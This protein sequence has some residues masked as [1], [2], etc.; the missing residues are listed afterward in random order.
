MKNTRVKSRE[1]LITDKDMQ[2]IADAYADYQASKEVK[3]VE[4]WQR[5]DK[6]IEDDQWPGAKPKDEW[7]PKPQINICWKTLQSIH[8]NITQGRTSIQVTS[9][10]P[11]YDDVSQDVAD[12]IEYYWDTLDMDR[13]LSELEWIRPKL[14]A[15][16]LKP[17]W[18]P[19]KANPFGYT[20]DLETSVVHPANCFPDPNITNPWEI[21]QADFID[22]VAPTTVKYIL[23]HFSRET[24]PLCN[25][26]REELQ[27]ILIP[28]TAFDDTEIYGDEFAISGKTPI[29]KD[30]IDRTVRTLNHRDRL[31]LHEYWYRDDEGKLQ[32]AW[33]AGWV[34]LKNTG[35][36]K[37]FTDGFYRHG[38]YP[39][40]I[41]P[42]I[43][44]D[45]R[46]WGRS[47]MQA[48]VARND[49]RDGLQDI[50]NK[51][52]QDYLIAFKAQGQPKLAYQ[53]GA[54]KNPEKITGDTDQVI[55]TRGIPSQVLYR[56]EGKLPPEAIPA[57]NAFM[58]FVDG[59]TNLWDVTQGRSTPYTQT[60]GGTMALLEQA[61]R[62][63][64]DRYSTLNDGLRE[65]A[66]IWL[67]HLAE[68][69]TVPREFTRERNG[70]PEVFEF[71]PSIILNAPARMLS[72]DGKVVDDPD[73][74]SRR[75]YFKI[76]I[77]VGATMAITRSYLTDLG[78]MLY[79]RKAIDL[80]GLYK[81]LPEF[82]GKQDAL[83]RMMQMMQ[84][85]QGGQAPQ[86]Q[87]AP[88]VTAEFIESLPP[89]LL[90][91]MKQ[92]LADEEIMQ[93]LQQM[94]QLPPE[95][96]D[97]Y[98]DQMVGGVATVGSPEAG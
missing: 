54:V 5:Y 15:A 22:Y 42:Y 65:M 57:V 37:M 12:V 44:R 90:M 78:M 93:H 1:K 85:Q 4:Q 11:L 33:L 53:H 71:N 74:E 79:E 38:R 70:Q 48:L 88:Q 45:K 61:M 14:G 84:A 77:D 73:G 34:L 13:K 68:F 6:Y 23:R 49:K 94:A 67:E 40:V 18:N 92:N 47:E 39:C 9:K 87:Q 76:S 86:G 55:P 83:D 64:N 66:E 52:I 46:L 75:I 3:P 30:G 26:T 19:N 27:Q 41:I 63:I 96:L 89:E 58:T 95:Q 82:P 59:L 7:K 20:G 16:I 24:D 98:V 91:W 81:L 2:F 8:A 50:V 17:Y 25:Y 29:S 10:F 80:P 51:I 43:Q 32:V 62:P 31:A 72:E 60:A 36:H 69:V 28:E 56:M 35:E 21:Q 97:A